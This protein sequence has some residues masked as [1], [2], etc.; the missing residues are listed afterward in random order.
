MTR[1]KVVLFDLGKVLVDFDWRVAAGRIAA[2]ARATPEDL[3]RFIQTSDVMVR[4]E[5][6]RIT[7]EQFFR[8]VQQAIGY[9][10]TMQDFRSAFSDIFSEIPEMVRL[11]ARLRAASVPTWIFS[12]TNDFAVTH[13]RERFPFFANFDGYFLSYELGVMKPHAGIY[14]AA[15]R[16]TGCHGAEIL[17]LDDFPE[18]VAGGVARGWQALQHVTPEQTVPLVERLVWGE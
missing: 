13:I 6:G 12:N 9:R 10:A 5:L 4:Y 11:Q 2:Q 7:S 15:E 1:P 14:E 17:Y 18:N 8:E 16:T 3:F